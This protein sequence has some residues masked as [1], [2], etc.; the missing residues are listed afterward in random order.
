VPKESKR[1]AAL[2]LGRIKGKHH[3]AYL[4]M[5]FAAFDSSSVVNV[6]PRFVDS[7]V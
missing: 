1:N 3:D 4:A 2:A 5:V 7:I 6:S